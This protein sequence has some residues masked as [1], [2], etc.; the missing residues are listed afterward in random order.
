MKA[1]RR[2]RPSEEGMVVR[3][4]S[5][6]LGIVLGGEW[7]PLALGGGAYGT[8][9]TLD[10]LSAI[11]QSVAEFGE[12]QAWASIGVALAAHNKQ[13]A[14]VDGT[15]IER[16]TDVQRAYGA[17]DTKA[18]AEL[19]Q[20]GW[21]DPQ[22]ITAGITVGFPLRRYGNTLQLTRQWMM[23]N[24][25]AQLAAEIAAIMDADRLNVIRA[26]KQ[27]L[28]S[29]TNYSFVDKLGG[30]TS[31]PNVTLAVKALV[32]NDGAGLPVGPNGETFATSHTHYLANATLTAAAVTNLIVTLQEHYNTGKPVLYI[33][34]TDE[35]AFRALAGFTAYVDARIIQPSTATYASGALEIANLYDRA[36]G[37]FGAAEVWI[38]PW[39][40][41]NYIFGYIQGPPPPLVMRQPTFAALGE[42]NLVTDDERYPLRARGYERQFG[43]GVWNRTNGAVL[44]FAGGAY[45]APTIT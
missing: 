43:M 28:F 44:Y 35:A 38:K 8:L 40:I 32:N 12:D 20:W 36:I 41:A 5:G 19:D 34:Q 1:L 37:V 14:D 3:S 24:S 26:A 22:K 21:P 2:F 27:A 23:Q 25:A 15:L 39:A 10:E 42:L 13:L 29:P 45:V 18:M 6:F 30:S 17:G 4:P 33:S 9:S 7:Q 16:T 31:A 11:R